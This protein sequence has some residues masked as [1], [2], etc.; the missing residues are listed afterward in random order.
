MNFNESQCIYRVVW[1]SSKPGT[2]ISQ[3]CLMR[4]ASSI[5]GCPSFAKGIPLFSTI[6]IEGNPV[7]ST[8]F[9]NFSELWEHLSV[10]PN[11]LF[12]FLSHDNPRFHLK[13]TR[14]LTIHLPLFCGTIVIAVATS[15]PTSPS[16]LPTQ[17]STEH[18]PPI[19]TTRSI[20]SFPLHRW[21]T[22]TA[23]GRMHA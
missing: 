9:C 21:I 15:Q 6:S 18:S 1:F 10:L 11:S 17:Q 16:P 8:S 12:S 2:G 20:E 23:T 7:F 22:I 13:I 5:V 4:G 3:Y 14:N 19:T